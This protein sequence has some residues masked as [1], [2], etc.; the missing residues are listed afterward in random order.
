MAVKGSRVNNRSRYANAVRGIPLAAAV[1]VWPDSISVPF[2]A[3]GHSRALAVRRS[4]LT[5]GKQSPHIASF[6][7]WC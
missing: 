7:R 1:G 3:E 6:T 2:A 5:V 4:Q